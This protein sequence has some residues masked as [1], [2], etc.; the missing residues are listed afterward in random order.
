[1]TQIDIDG[2]L[3]ELSL[4]PPVTTVTSLLPPDGN[5]QNEHNSLKS[6]DIVGL[7]PP[8]PLLPPENTTPAENCDWKPTF[9]AW[10]EGDVLMISGVTDDLAGEII[11]LTADDLSLQR[12]LLKRHCGIYDGPWWSRLV[13]R[14]QER[15]GIM[16]YDGGL[17]REDAEYQAAECLRAAAF[18]EELKKHQEENAICECS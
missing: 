1:M 9:H 7:L 2:I 14:W 6:D 10:L 15:A 4:Y 12:Q 16:Q 18:F 11:K 3:P 5:G 8:L 17:T 13:E